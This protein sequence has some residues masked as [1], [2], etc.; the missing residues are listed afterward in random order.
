M[1][2]VSAE[3][4]A[5]LQQEVTTLCSCWR[6]ERQDGVILGFTDHDRSFTYKSLYYEAQ[7]GF[8]RSAFAS[9]GS[10]SVDNLEVAGFLNSD[11][12]DEQEMRNG[13]YNHAKVF[14]FLVNW[15]DLSM[16][17][18]A[19]RRG[20]FGEITTTS[21]GEFTVELRGMTQAL[22]HQTTEN[23]S[24]ECRADFCDQRCGLS[25]VEYQQITTVATKSSDPAVFTIPAITAP[26]Q[27]YAGGTVEWT[28][29]Q[30]TGRVMEISAYDATSR[31]ITLF[32]Q[33]AY[34]IA[35]GDT[36]K[37][38]PGC[39]KTRDSCKV[40]KNI[41]NFRGEPDVPGQ[42]EYLTYPDSHDG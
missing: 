24:P 28:A 2:S 41:L 36:L 38:A 16:G 33:M 17:E 30:N 4:Q 5:H 35:I 32:E 7:E 3:M 22:A 21:N 15:K 10:Y 34:P 37:I 26:T 39:D 18:I 9:D 11:F 42:D 6:I 31:T 20:W 29:G 8:T 40:Y 12:L 1:K 19:M 27:G 23:F 13:L 25:L 14:V